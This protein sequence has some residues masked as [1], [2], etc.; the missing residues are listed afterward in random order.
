MV[1]V[2]LESWFEF[3]LNKLDVKVSDNG[4]FFIGKILS[5][6]TLNINHYSSVIIQRNMINNKNH[7]TLFQISGVIYQSDN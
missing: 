5:F 4:R 7:C 2:L 1:E 6:D 3:T